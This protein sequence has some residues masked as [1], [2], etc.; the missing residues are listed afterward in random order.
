MIEMTRMSP[1]PLIAS[2][3]SDMLSW[4]PVMFIDTRRGPLRSVFGVVVLSKAAIFPILA[5]APLTFGISALATLR[6]LAL[7]VLALVILALVILALVPSAL[8]TLR[9]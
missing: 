6:I 1:A 2:A 7:V 4:V 3:W 5:L 9:I 8:A